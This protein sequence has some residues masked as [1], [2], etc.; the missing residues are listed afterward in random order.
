MRIELVDIRRIARAI[1]VRRIAERARE[2]IAL[3]GERDRL[4][5]GPLD[6]RE[7]IVDFAECLQGGA[8]IGERG[9][10]ATRGGGVGLGAQTLPMLLAVAQKGLRTSSVGRPPSRAFR[11]ASIWSIR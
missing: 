11:C 6:A 1:S 2:R 3:A 7:A 10:I 5:A 8:A 9:L 4:L